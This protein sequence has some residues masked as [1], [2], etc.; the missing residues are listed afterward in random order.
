MFARSP[1]TEVPWMDPATDG[2]RDPSPPDAQVA[3]LAR[4]LAET[5]DQQAATSEVL[6]AI[7]PH[8]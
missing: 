6:A 2:E 4:A 1:L 3:R 8:A 7:G 5:R